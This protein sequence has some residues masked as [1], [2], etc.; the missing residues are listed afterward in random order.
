MGSKKK[1]EKIADII[2]QDTRLQSGFSP[3]IQKR[4]CDLII[5]SKQNVI[6]RS[7]IVTAEQLYE[8][9]CKL[10]EMAHPSNSITIPLKNPNNHEV[11]MQ[12]QVLVGGSANSPQYQIFEMIRKLP[13]F[14]KY[15][16]VPTL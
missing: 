4:C 7:A 2:P 13:K 15:C 12:I 3:N 10:Y 1:G 9:E 8:G 16:F 6:I 11:Q 14:S 5:S